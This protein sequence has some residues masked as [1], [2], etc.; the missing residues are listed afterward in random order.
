MPSRSIVRMPWATASRRSSSVVAQ[1]TIRRR[2][3]GVMLQ[4]LVHAD[5]VAV[6]GAGAV[7]AAHAVE[8][9]R[10]VAAAAVLPEH[11]ELVGA[12][13]VRLLAGVADAAHSAAPTTP[14]TAEAMRKASMPM[15]RKRCTAATE[16]VPC[17]DDSTK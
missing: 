8:E 3:S 5:A 2:S 7:V 9:L 10:L 14:T 12:G 13:R 15:S 4:Q 11:G 17:S 1:P 16:S 6:A